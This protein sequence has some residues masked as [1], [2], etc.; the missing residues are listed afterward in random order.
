MKFEMNNEVTDSIKDAARDKLNNLF[1]WAV[2]AF[3][4]RISLG[5]SCHFIVSNLGVKPRTSSPSF[6]QG[7]CDSLVSYDAVLSQ[8]LSYHV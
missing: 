3:L 5:F 2:C 7:S 1:L 6:Q 4:V 8:N